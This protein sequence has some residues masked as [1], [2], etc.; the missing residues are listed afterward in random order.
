MKSP[1]RQFR[2]SVAHDACDAFIE[3]RDFP[4]PEAESE[5]KRVVH[6]G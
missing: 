3:G 2:D 5:I 4:L 1:P 6:P